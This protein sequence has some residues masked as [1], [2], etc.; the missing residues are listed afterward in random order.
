MIL[1][2]FQ[3]VPSNEIFQSSSYIHIDHRHTYAEHIIMLCVLRHINVKPDCNIHNNR[4]HGVAENGQQWQ[5]A[6]IHID[7]NAMTN[8][9]S[10]HA[11]Q[12]LQNKTL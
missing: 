7:F 1:N 4:V 10:Q 2:G 9:R 5:T 11:E 8:S 6:C 3:F 12:L